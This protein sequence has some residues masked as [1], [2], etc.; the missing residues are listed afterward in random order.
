M[1]KGRLWS[2]EEIESNRLAYEKNTPLH[3]EEVFKL[4]ED[5]EKNSQ[6]EN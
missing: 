1:N 6:K 5:E 2:F 4:I 3:R